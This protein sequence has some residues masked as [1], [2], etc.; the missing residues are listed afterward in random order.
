MRDPYSFGMG[1]T[2]TLVVIGL[3]L[4]TATAGKPERGSGRGPAYRTT[5]Q[6]KTDKQKDTKQ[7]IPKEDS[8]VADKQKP[9]K[10]QK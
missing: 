3:I 2:C 5:I 7:E 1:V 9:F 8:E 6:Q 10:R 4:A